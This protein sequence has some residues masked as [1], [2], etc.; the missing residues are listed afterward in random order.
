MEY[1]YF[2]ATGLRIGA[3]ALGAQTFGWT[4]DEK[5]SSEILNRYY[6][7]GGNYLD[8]ADSYN[9]GESERIVGGWMKE[10][11]VRDSIVLGT[12]VFFPTG[13]GPNDEGLSRKHIFQSVEESLRRLQT[14]YID[15]YQIH[16]FDQRTP[17]EETLRAL[18]DLVHSGKVR[19]LGASNV[20]PSLLQKSLM[21]GK[22]EGLATFAVL[23]LEYS[24]LVRSPE[25]E[26]L[27]QCEREVV[28]TLAWSPLAGGWLSGKYRRG[29][30]LPPDSR[31]GKG[32]RWDDAEDQ[33]GGKK[34][35]DII[36]VLVR[37]GEE[38]GRP[39]SQVALNWLL[40]KRGVTSALIGARTLAQ[41]NENLGTTEWLLDAEHSAALD[42]V[43]DVGLPYPYSF[44]AKYTRA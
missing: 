22:Y 4:T 17:I 37:I 21:L 42:A 5:Q 25:W 26:L 9:K 8:A 12:K 34:T 41:L 31:A 32:E 19:Y 35:Y 2:G 6:E 27:P 30:Q 15:L 38:L 10:H 3:I 7:C 40:R 28:G 20:T 16:C 23:Q 14:D 36:D 29:M 13:K 11:R 39:P 18:D 44:I 24:L 33:R 1:R 43:S